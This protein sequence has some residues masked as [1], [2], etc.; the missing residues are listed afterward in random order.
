M[1]ID[2]RSENEGN[3]R[4]QTTRVVDTTEVRTLI[5]FWRF[6]FFLLFLF[7]PA[8]LK[9][10]PFFFWGSPKCGSSLPLPKKTNYGR[11]KK[12]VKLLFF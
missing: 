4:K 7:K 6:F 1:A 3:A 12:G 8:T 2:D 11:K 5:T 10:H 9:I